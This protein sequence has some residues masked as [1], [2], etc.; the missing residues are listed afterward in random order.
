MIRIL[1]A[2]D[3]AMVRGALSALLA[4]EADIEVLGAA[5]DGEAA[6]R[7]LQR[8]KPDVLVTDIEM[9]GLSGL[10]LAQRIQRHGLPVKVII[11]TTF[12]PVSYTHLDVYKRQMMLS[13]AVLLAAFSYAWHATGIP[14]IYMVSTLIAGPVVALF[15]IG[16]RHKMRADAKLRLSHEEVR[17]L[18][19]LAERERIG[20]DL[21]DL[22]G[23]TLS[24]VA[25]KSE[26]ASRLVERDPAAARKEIE[27]VS[28]VARDALAQVR[29]AV[30][31]IRAAGLAAELASARLL[32]ESDGIRF[33]YAL[34]EVAL[35]PEHETVLAPVSY[36][37]LDV[38]KRQ[39][40]WADGRHCRTAGIGWSMATLPAEMPP[41]LIHLWSL[42]TCAMHASRT[43]S[44]SPWMTWTCSCA[45]ARCW[46]C[47][48]PM[49]RARARRC[50]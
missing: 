24:L 11:V 36:T 42:P 13:M 29:R 5:A 26:L 34:D 16:M 19:A 20:R 2:E 17:R 39:P 27:E 9:P 44:C 48:A 31:G 47:W 23:H 45:V 35:S 46:P 40:D 15:N 8:L 50:R 41:W 7:D 25:L 33:S 22:L 12:A 1:L 38:Y 32:L 43:A 18:A 10:E 49:A 6:W 4:M 28:G 30:T 3:Q 37:H 14:M 21:H